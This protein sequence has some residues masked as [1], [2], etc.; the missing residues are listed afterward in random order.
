L[1]GALN[2]NIGVIKS[3]MAEVTDPTNIALAYSFMPIAWSTG[4]T[5]G[6]MIGGSLSRPADQF[7]HLFGYS[8][9]LKKYPYFLP[10]AI[11][12]TFSALA[13][14]IT[15]LFLKETV[16]NPVSFS[17][18]LGLRKPKVEEDASSEDR[19]VL[20]A[21]TEKP[22]SLRALLTS[23]VIV[24]AG[25]YSTLSLMDISFR[26]IQP[27]FLSTPIHLGGLGLSPASIGQILSVTGIINGVFQIGFFAKIH[28]RWGSKRTFLVGILSGFP[29]ILTLPVA[30]YF[31]RADGGLS[32][33]VWAVVW[34]QVA[35]SILTSLSYGSVFIFISSAAPRSSLGAVNGLSQMSVS[36]VRAIGPSIANSMF[37]LS[38][39]DP[40]P[41]IGGNLVYIVLL[42]IVVIA[43][44]AASFLP[45]RAWNA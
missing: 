29:M 1:N 14:V 38:M 31:A 16:P 9:F 26:A 11:P 2:G 33:R 41:I 12:A 19:S 20:P 27:L 34:F 32:G 37:S 30:N 22:P 43:T 44:V 15:Y 6:P 17:T 28:D 7:P 25:N 23:R 35:V 45:S 10:C 13:W 21:P 40:L 4:A 3:M 8:E 42:S 24:S 39:E 18:L 5:I 36:I